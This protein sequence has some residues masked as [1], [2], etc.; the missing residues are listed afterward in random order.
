MIAETRRQI[1]PTQHIPDGPAEAIV[2]SYDDDGN[3]IK[4]YPYGYDSKVSYL[5]ANIVL[6]FVLRDFSKNNPVGATGYNTAGLPL[7]FGRNYAGHAGFFNW[8]HPE[9]I[10]YNC[11]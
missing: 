10:E 4:P 1:Y 6:Q 9:T 3:L 2:Y 7:G 11:R 8:G 5:S